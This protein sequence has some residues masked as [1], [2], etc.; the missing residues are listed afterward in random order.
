LTPQPRRDNV[1]GCHIGINATNG[2]HTAMPLSRDI[3]TY[4]MI[5]ETL[6]QIIEAG[7]HAEYECASAREAIRFR[8]EV[9]MFRSLLEKGRKDKEP[10][11]KNHSDYLMYSQLRLIISPDRPNVVVFEDKT[12]RG[13]LTLLHGKPFAYKIVR[14]PEP[15]WEAAK[16]QREL[17][18]LLPE[19]TS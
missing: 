9:Y 18:D 11:D 12:E 3:N 7:C 1:P 19:G 10:T 5:K 2:A 4:V 17:D 16:R 8:Q 13:K 14:A 6:D 15:D